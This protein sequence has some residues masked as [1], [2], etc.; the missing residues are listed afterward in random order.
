MCYLELVVT[1]ELYDDGHDPLFFEGFVLLLK[2]FHVKQ[3][4]LQLFFPNRQISSKP[5]SHQEL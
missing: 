3:L 2:D 5:A 1:L 4:G